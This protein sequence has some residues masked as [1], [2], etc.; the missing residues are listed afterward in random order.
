MKGFFFFWFLSEVLGVRLLSSGSRVAGLGSWAFPEALEVLS[1]P[2]TRGETSVSPRH[3]Q[4][5]T[6]WFQAMGNGGLQVTGF[7]SYEGLRGLIGCVLEAQGKVNFS[8][9]S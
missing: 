8:I 2:Q 6:S 4:R 3:P 7:S 1:E 5:M 9:C